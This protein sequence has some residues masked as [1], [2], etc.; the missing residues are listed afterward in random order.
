MALEHLHPGESVQLSP[1]SSAKDART[2]ALV[3]TDRFEAVK[4]VLHARDEISE[5]AV[6][7]YATLLCLEGV[8]TLRLNDDVRLDAGAWLYLDRGQRH[9]IS[10]IEDSSLLLTILFD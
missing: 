10:A 7:G 5:H 2:M 3:K 8:I 9:S 6:A 1:V 4:I